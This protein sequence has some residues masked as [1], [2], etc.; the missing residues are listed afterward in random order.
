MDTGDLNQKVSQMSQRI[1][2]LEDAL[3]LLQSQISTE[4]HPL[5]R[6]ELLHVKDLPEKRPS[7]EPDASED[8]L[9]GEPVDAFG[10]LTI[11][12]SGESL[13]FG[14]TAGSEVCSASD[15]SLRWH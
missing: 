14:A 12:N 8:P 15:T 10:T 1:R 9:A 6:D 7:A 3:V 11:D 5:L 4:P 2:D 13:Y